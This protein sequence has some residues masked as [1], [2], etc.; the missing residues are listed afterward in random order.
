MKNLK[1]KKENQTLNPTLTQKQTLNKSINP[2]CSKIKAKTK[3][4]QTLKLNFNTNLK[5][6][7]PLN[8][9]P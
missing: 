2:R 9:K 8:L 3:K 1:P 6:I 4:T 5:I 7:K